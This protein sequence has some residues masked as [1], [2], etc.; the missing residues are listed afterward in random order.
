M[1]LAGNLGVDLV[2]SAIAFLLG[3]DI[4]IFTHTRQCIFYLTE[5]CSCYVG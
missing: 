1:L 3:D 5:K 2:V 4:L